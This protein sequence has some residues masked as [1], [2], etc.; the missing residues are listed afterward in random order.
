MK[1]V[2]LI[3]LSSLVLHA[4]SF[5]VL[6]GV[7]EYDPLVESPAELA[8]Y[9]D[10]IKEEM[11][12]MS[13]ELKINT[14]NHPSRVLAFIISKFSVGETLA[15]KIELELAEYMKRDGEKEGVFSLS[16]LDTRMFPAES[17]IEDMLMDNVDNMLAK[18]A[19]QYKDD[20]KD[21][22]DAKVG[23]THENFA[24]QMEYET[25]YNVAL[26][27]A[28]KEGKELFIFMSTTY[29]PWCRKIEK[30]MLSKVDIDKKIKEHYVP[31]KL[32]FSKKNFPLRLV[33]KGMIP[34][35]YVMD[36]NTKEISGEFVGYN[37]R[38]DFLYLL[39]KK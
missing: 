31:L 1:I 5:F 37:N 13:K 18:F 8:I 34:T 4:Q 25:D 23:L 36:A 27:K 11:L 24:E 22:S 2:L 14:A 38:E 3:F 39:N 19:H 32:N 35:L 16:Y 9:T 20:N 30:R 6:T 12:D 28:K 26:A 15:Y 29:C 33:G 21:K 17:D 7:N 10:E